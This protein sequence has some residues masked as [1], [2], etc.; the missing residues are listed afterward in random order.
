MHNWIVMLGLWVEQGVFK[1]LSTIVFFSLRI[2]IFLSVITV[3][4]V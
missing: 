1:L 2:S 3:Y 4:N